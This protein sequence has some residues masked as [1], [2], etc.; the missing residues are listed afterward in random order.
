MIP[1][2]KINLKLPRNAC[3]AGELESSSLR[4]IYG[5]TST[6]KRTCDNKEVHKEI[7]TVLVVYY[8]SISPD[9]NLTLFEWPSFFVQGITWSI[10]SALVYVKSSGLKTMATSKECFAAGSEKCPCFAELLLHVRL[11]SFNADPSSGLVEMFH[12]GC[13][14]KF[15]VSSWSD[16]DTTVVCRQLGFNSGMRTLP[17]SISHYPNDVLGGRVTCAGS[18]DNLA[19]CNVSL[20]D[21]DDCRELVEIQCSGE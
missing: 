8:S 9:M 4:L 17:S 7:M 6:P 20:G 19:Y 21:H 3:G 14:Q 2:K 10:L 11:R 1:K 13:W 18:E 16:N 12:D 5:L 15:C